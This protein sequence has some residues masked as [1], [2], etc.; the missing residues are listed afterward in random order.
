MSSGSSRHAASASRMARSM[1]R[2]AKDDGARAV[3]CVDDAEAL[4]E[5]IRQDATFEMLFAIATKENLGR[6]VVSAFGMSSSRLFCI[7]AQC[8]FL[9]F[10]SVDSFSGSPERQIHVDTIIACLGRSEAAMTMLH[11]GLSKVVKN[12]PPD[13]FS[14]D[15]PA[16]V[17][18]F[19]LQLFRLRLASNT[20]G[21]EDVP[22]VIKN[23]ATLIVDTDW[24]CRAT[25]RGQLQTFLAADTVHAGPA[26][27]AAAASSRLRKVDEMLKEPGGRHSND[28]AN[29]R[30][31]EIL[32]STDEISSDADPFLPL[33]RAVD[34]VSEEDRA[35]F[36]LD[37]HFRLL[38][39]DFLGPLRKEVDIIRKDF[40]ANVRESRRLKNRTF[41][42]LWIVNV[43]PHS[44]ESAGRC[45]A[46]VE[47]SFRHPWTHPIPTMK[48]YKL[49]EEQGR[50]QM[51]T[52][53]DGSRPVVTAAVKRRASYWT[54]H[55]RLLQ[56]RSVVCI[57]LPDKTPVIGS[58]CWRPED[59]GMGVQYPSIGVEFHSHEDLTRIL[60]Y[61][62]NEEF[63]SAFMVQLS[64]SYFAIEPVLR[65]LQRMPSIPLS[66]HL[67][68][69]EER[70]ESWPAYVRRS[71]AM[72]AAV[73]N[74]DRADAAADMRPILWRSWAEAGSKPLVLDKSQKAAILG[75]MMNQV[76]LIQ[77]PPGTGKSFCGA[78]IGRMII[79]HT[80]STILVV[81]YTNHAL[82][83]FLNDLIDIGV[84]E[85]DIVR[86]GS[87]P[88]MDPKI[89]RLCLKYRIQ[90]LARSKETNRTFGK[91]KDRL[92]EALAEAKQKFGSLSV[93]QKTAF[94]S[95]SAWM[96][97]SRHGDYEAFQELSTKTEDEFGTVVGAGGKSS[98]KPD[99]TFFRWRKG[100][101]RPA[102]VEAIVRPEDSLWKLSKKERE[103][104]LSKWF[105]DMAKEDAAEAADCLTEAKDVL[106][107][108][109]RM[110]H[111][112]NIA[113]LRNV[114]IIG[115]TT[116]SAAMHHA[117]LS[118][119]APDVLLVEEAGEILESHILSSLHASSQHLIMIGDHQQL[120]PK[121]TDYKM[122]V[123]SRRGLDLNKS[124]FERLIVDGYYPHTTLQLQHRMRPEFAELVQHLTYPEL[125]NAPA[126]LGRSS[127]RGLQKDF[128]F[129]DHSKEEGS[130]GQSPE[131]AADS[132]EDSVSKVNMFEVE[133]VSET[134][135]YLLKQDYEE[136]EI[137]VLT[138]YLAQLYEL[139][140]R[141]TKLR[142]VELNE[143]DKAELAQAGLDDSDGDIESAED[144]KSE[145]G[146]ALEASK[147][148]RASSSK[149]ESTI[150]AAT[151]DNFQGEEGDIVV[152]SLVRSNG[153]GSIG[154]LAEP[155][156]VNVLLSR[157][158]AGMIIFGD[159]KTLCS[160]KNPG[161]Q[162]L[163]LKVRTFLTDKRYIFSGLPVRC[164]RH[165]DRMALIATPAD[166]KTIFPD[167]GCNIPC[168]V[169]LAC[170]HSCTLHCHAPEMHAR[171]R[172][173]TMCPGLCPKG[174]ALQYKCCDSVPTTCGTCQRNLQET[175]R[176][177]KEQLERQVRQNEEDAAYLAAKRERDAKEAAL[178]ADLDR[179]QINEQRQK[180]AAAQ[181]ESIRFRQAELAQKQRNSPAEIAAAKQD[182]KAAT[183]AQIARLLS[184]TPVSK[185][186][187]AA[188]GNRLSFPAVGNFTQNEEVNEVSC[189]TFCEREGNWVWS[190]MQ[191]SLRN[192]RPRPTAPKVTQILTLCQ[193]EEWLDA[194]QRCDKAKRDSLPRSLAV[195]CRAM[196]DDCN[197]GAFK[198][199]VEQSSAQYELA[200]EADIIDVVCRARALFEIGKLRKDVALQ[201]RGYLLA[202]LGREMLKSSLWQNAPAREFLGSLCSQVD[203]GMMAQLREAKETSQ[204]NQSRENKKAQHQ[205]ERYKNVDAASCASLDELMKMIGIESV[206]LGFLQMWLSM[207]AEV[208]QVAAIPKTES[209]KFEKNAPRRH[210]IL[211]GNPGAGKT[212]VAKLYGQFLAQVGIWKGEVFVET[213][214]SKLLTDGSTW[215]REKI[216]EIQKARGGVLFI[217]EVYQLNPQSNREG[218][219]ILDLL[220]TEMEDKRAHFAVVFAGYKKRIEQLMEHNEGLP[221]RFSRTFNVDDFSDEELAEIVRHQF[222]SIRYEHMRMADEKLFRILARRVGA[223]RGREGFGNARDVENAVQQVM[224]RQRERV[225]KARLDGR[226]VDMNQI[227]MSDIVG[228]E[229]RP[230]LNSIPEWKKLNDMI[231]LQKV[232][233]AVKAIA[234]TVEQN[235]ERE[236]QEQPLLQ[237]SLNRVFLGNPGT[238]KTTVAGL[239]A[240]VVKGLGL[241][242]KGDLIATKP[243]DFKGS[244]IGESEKKTRALLARARGCVLLIDE[245]YGLCPKSRSA[246]ASGI[247]DPFKADVIDAIVGEVQGRPG[248]DLCVILCGYRK[249]MEHM[250]QVSNP[251]LARRFNLADAFEFA[252]YSKTELAKL[253]TTKAKERT[254]TALP[255]DAL[256][257]AVEELE[258]QK[259]RP[260]FG[261]GGAVDNLLSRAIENWQKRAAV[262][263]SV[264]LE[265]AD[266]MSGS[267]QNNEP[268]SVEEILGSLEGCEA[269][270]AKLCALEKAVRW[271]ASR[272]LNPMEKIATNFRFVGPPGTGKTTV[273]RKIGEVF[274][275]LGLVATADVE[276]VTPKDLVA[277][278]VGQ[279]AKKTRDVFDRARGRVLFI[280]E[281]YGLNSAPGNPFAK[282]AVE[283]MLAIMTDPEYKGKMVVIL[284]GYREDIDALLESNAGM[285]S[286][287]G[288]EVEFS[289]FTTEQC[290]RLLTRHLSTNGF[291]LDPHAQQVA[292]PWFEKLQST[293]GWANGRDVET[294][295]KK[296]EDAFI[297]QYEPS[298][299]DAAD[300]GSTLYVAQEQ[301]D[302]VLRDFYKERSRPARAMANAVQRELGNVAAATAMPPKN[303]TATQVSTRQEQQVQQE[304]K[305][306]QAKHQ[307]KDAQQEHEQKARKQGGKEGPIGDEWLLSGLR[308]ALK[309]LGL[310]RDESIQR[311]V[312]SDESDKVI[313]REVAQQTGRRIDEV[314]DALSKLQKEVQKRVQRKTKVP[315]IQ[316]LICGSPTCPT[317]PAVVGYLEVLLPQA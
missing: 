86:L 245:A 103:A 30:D 110:R 151:I 126:V 15:E 192:A 251:G 77:G 213:T 40:P 252:D 65:Q 278:F 24:F 154:F 28:H 83:Q 80:D 31:I 206:K 296:L 140:K 299:E 221:S 69:N 240:R 181:Q 48:R 105:M 20:S 284:A 138:P 125:R 267:A 109:E 168:G 174:H 283:E 60:K 1:V 148:T 78:L 2:R 260:H 104:R 22:T 147:P 35:A 277:E 63:A 38:R 190:A 241:L 96:K 23:I 42:S 88:K 3:T 160:S 178:Q 290:I 116:T 216:D 158:R 234:R 176:L 131:T 254:G 248:D 74:L 268:Q 9:C 263:R 12:G 300:D 170:G 186:N 220:L 217:D 258:R 98:I 215:L 264:H 67:L 292:A 141:L 43:L 173:T 10:L 95:L 301:A 276:A 270:K 291:G 55:R 231:G 191:A 198:E 130:K 6:A 271:Y 189:R 61:T 142:R 8:G 308:I 317:R 230:D 304:T 5:E 121:V 243:S 49:Q 57:M 222:S 7:G 75:A 76:G 136:Q 112:K 250:M 210:M 64:V 295:A 4:I 41:H 100:D 91:L 197:S 275:V 21:N 205:W 289:H 293:E 207:R 182:A 36:T 285:K 282:E 155:E 124:L 146:D 265:A 70:S 313:A 294:I 310:S 108:M 161:G 19:V 89:E 269:V 303:K 185:V 261:N 211:T 33:A 193:N 101:K 99:A 273:A 144:K 266:F 133:M 59:T 244:V 166:F 312:G 172:C 287:F 157:A 153:K 214:G 143:L 58:I 45:S 145:T 201:S 32:P 200:A 165:P 39:E 46:G 66:D 227:E 139:R 236:Q 81:C 204:R 286:R 305:Q 235:F 202:L 280:D 85:D 90:Q 199:F 93:G 188:A 54:E 162:A 134:V 311:L 171:I 25:E 279:T 233:Q 71:S 47:I 113:A 169:K 156:R 183:D 246:G 18:W 196:M 288:E 13:G 315:V 50:E 114:R 53:E 272:G 117:E 16:A 242:S 194:G 177:Q 239:F 62:A 309:N 132:L 256:H 149:S 163:W 237:L 52:K 225:S 180:S 159:L 11:D 94:K 87:S 223:G 262:D 274:K 97:R 224:D 164:Q 209:A 253:L 123:Q 84:N 137:V 129:V 175:A 249:D 135:A 195:L 68:L 118:A 106:Q 127:I 184:K 115:C 302:R 228:V 102:H 14:T 27:K 281:A 257:V 122:Q 232:K 152:I 306:G 51:T 29:F 307:E 219:Q 73:R 259:R 119:I 212:T 238:G 218:G 34:D 128:V 187:E 92:R 297:R 203:E 37:R 82:D 314:L 79:E 107:T 226:M 56:L 17:T 298:S 208:Q 26:A 111:E 150:R 120:R 316:C 72:M 179:L 229:G 247:D 44:V 255:D 167:G